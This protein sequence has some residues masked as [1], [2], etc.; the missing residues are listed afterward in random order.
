M[1]Y[2]Q[3]TQLTD[4]QSS[5]VVEYLVFV[6]NCVKQVKSILT[7]VFVIFVFESI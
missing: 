5:G 4:K 2:D 3:Y 6:F 7:T 1:F